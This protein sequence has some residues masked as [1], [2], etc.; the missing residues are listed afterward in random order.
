MFSP[1]SGKTCLKPVL[2]N[3]DTLRY[4]DSM[5]Y[6]FRP[7][8]RDSCFMCGSILHWFLL[9]HFYLLC[10]PI[11]FLHGA[12]IT[13]S[14][15]RLDSGLDDRGV[16]ARFPTGQDIFLFSTAS[17]PA[18]GPTQPPIKWVLGEKR[19]GRE[20]DYT[21]PSSA[22]VKNNGAIPLLPYT[23]SWPGA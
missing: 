4:I 15:Q 23:S 7:E 13:H 18:L 11:H 5:Y 6:W 17:K 3:I 22:E 19:Q 14:V 12:G 1:V 9:K 16:G 21:P 20:A 10:F 8:A 2:L